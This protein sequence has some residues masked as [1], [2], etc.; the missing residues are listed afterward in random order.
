MGFKKGYIMTKEHKLGGKTMIK[1]KKTYLR[2]V[3]ILEIK[4]EF[5]EGDI[6]K[7][8]EYWLKVHNK[9]PRY[10]EL[11]EIKTKK[12]NQVGNVKNVEKI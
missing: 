10:F 3:N 7:D 6:E 8:K 1:N 5:F 2:F 4:L 12:W 9:I 11:K